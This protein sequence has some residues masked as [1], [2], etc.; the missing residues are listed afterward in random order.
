MS[1]IHRALPENCV[2]APLSPTEPRPLSGHTTTSYCHGTTR[3]SETRTF[4]PPL[5]L[6][7][8]GP[9]L[10]LRGQPKV[11][12][13]GPRKPQ[14]ASVSAASHVCQQPNERMVLL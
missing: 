13:A 2:F 12:G 4:A 7:G 14:T 1:V 6:G 5:V 3:A 9:W 10:W 8:R 11:K